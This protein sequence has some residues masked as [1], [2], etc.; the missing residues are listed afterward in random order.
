MI[1][2]RTGFIIKEW[3]LSHLFEYQKRHVAK[4]LDDL[5]KEFGEELANVYDEKAVL[6]MKKY[7]KQRNHDEW[8]HFAPY[9]G[10]Y[11]NS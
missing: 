9:L 7:A 4:K 2:L 3:D 10:N 11:N 5:N 8:I 6:T 1:D